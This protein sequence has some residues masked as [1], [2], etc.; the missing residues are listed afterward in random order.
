MYQLNNSVTFSGKPIGSEE[1][2]N[3]MVEA[4]GII[5]VDVLK[6]DLVKWKAKPQ[7]KQDVSL[8]NLK[9]L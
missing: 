2:L 4:L 9:D 6:K 8:F 7:K 1:F 3:Q 5:Q